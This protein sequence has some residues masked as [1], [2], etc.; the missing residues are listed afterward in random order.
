[1]KRKR[2]SYELIG[3]VL[4]QAEAGR[5]SRRFDSKWGLPPAIPI[6]IDHHPWAHSRVPIEMIF[7]GWSMSWFQA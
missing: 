3:S 4:R 1:M 2:Y 5:R 6:P 7:Q